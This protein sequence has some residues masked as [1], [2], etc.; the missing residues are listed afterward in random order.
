MV[1]SWHITDKR[2]TSCYIVILIMYANTVC[3]LTPV[4]VPSILTIPT[5]I[6]K[7]LKCLHLMWCLFA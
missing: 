3:R 1:Q 7:L 5:S 4:T 6:G 2:C